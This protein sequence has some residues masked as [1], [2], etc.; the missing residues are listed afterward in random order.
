M[1]KYEIHQIINLIYL[2]LITLII[3]Y[4]Y[5]FDFNNN[6]TRNSIVIYFLSILLDE[7]SSEDLSLPS[8]NYIANAYR[9]SRKKIASFFRIGVSE[10]NYP[11]LCL[12]HQ[13]IFN[14]SG[15]TK[16]DHFVNS[17]LELQQIFQNKIKMNERIH[18]CILPSRQ[19]DIY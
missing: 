13:K 11:I 12:R 2:D 15:K 7:K 14:A 1:T 4:N 17:L 8:K 5:Q 10:G 3:K 19:N 16:D 18:E 9:S 6:R